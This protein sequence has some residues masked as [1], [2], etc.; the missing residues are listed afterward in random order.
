MNVDTLVQ[1]LFLSG[2]GILAG[3]L[4]GSVIIVMLRLRKVVS[5]SKAAFRRRAC[6]FC[7]D[8]DDDVLLCVVRSV[9]FVKDH[10]HVLYRSSKDGVSLQATDSRTDALFGPVCAQCRK[11]FDIPP[12]LKP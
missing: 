7:E 8:T 5:Q 11:Q 10:E 1:G 9:V 2:I 6:H 3:I 12:G 4:I